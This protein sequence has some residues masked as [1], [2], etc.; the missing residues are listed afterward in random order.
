MSMGN[1][2]TI[3]TKLRIANVT[4]AAV[5][6]WS[7]GIWTHI[8]LKATEGAIT[9]NTSSGMLEM[10]PAFAIVVSILSMM[11]AFIGFAAKY[12]WDGCNS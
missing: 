9:Y 6:L 10:T 8:I 4:A 12:L 2:P 1:K 7:F 5:I 3:F 11:N